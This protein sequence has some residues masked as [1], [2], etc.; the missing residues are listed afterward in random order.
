MQLVG[1]VSGEVSPTNFNILMANTGI[2]KGTYVK[3]NHEECGF[4]LARI[5]DLKRALNNSG[6]EVATAKAYTIGYKDESVVKM[7]K[8]PFKPMERVYTADS[9]L[10]TGVIGLQRT[11]SG[12]IYLGV[13]DGC[14]IPVYLDLNRT[15]RKHVSILAMTGAGK[16]YTVG[17]LLEE[18]L[19]N[20]IPIV[21]IDPHREYS[22]LR[23]ENDDFDA[24]V[25][26]G[27]KPASYASKVVEYTTNPLTNPG[28]KRFGLRSR[29]TVEELSEMMPVR[30]G[31]KQKMI[32]YNAMRR[33]ESQDY[34][35][36]DLIN[37]VRLEKGG[38]KWKVLSV[39]E[40]LR[41]SGVFDG[42]PVTEK[43]LVKSGKASIIDLKGSEPW[44]QQLVVA[45]IARDLFNAVKL[46]E[47]PPFFFLIEEAHNFCPERGFGDAISSEILRT[48]ASEGR[49][50]GLHLCVVSQR[51]ARVDKNVLSQCNTQVI[52]KVTNPNDLRAIGQSIEGFTYGMENDIKQLSVGQALVVGECVEQPITVNI[53]ARESRHIGAAEAKGKKPE[54]PVK[55]PSSIEKI[56]PLF[57]KD[58]K[59]K[60][61]IKAVEE[62]QKD[63]G[64]VRAKKKGL[65]QKVVG[66]FLRDA[67]EVQKK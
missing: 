32:L 39:L 5:S 34:T 46:G 36:Q 3:V 13:L 47:L 59:A 15:I 66:I 62:L 54:Q 58:G 23:Y 16:S 26:Y 30:I 8:T 61:G 20:D 42:R 27:V 63:A 12:N 38:D 45:R 65:K 21:I 60:G 17:V 33:L 44:V 9:E 18:L 57:V 51:P 6:E 35:M 43:E 40:S 1:V 4:V 52:L 22:S 7:P 56:K 19:K 11:R 49:K 24:M 53:R 2:G 10:I 28:A 41:N 67:Q 55:K 48:I 29:F 50:F 64:V 31:D 14:R 25:A 37:T